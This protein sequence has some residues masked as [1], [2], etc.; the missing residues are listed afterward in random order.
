MLST[1]HGKCQRLANRTSSPQLSPVL[2]RVGSGGDGASAQLRPTSA[3]T[4][5]PCWL[6]FEVPSPSYCDTDICLGLEEKLL[7]KRNLCFVPMGIKPASQAMP[8]PVGGS[9]VQLM[10]SVAQ[11]CFVLFYFFQKSC[12]FI[13]PTFSLPI[14]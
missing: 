7:L 11:V 4:A 9:R 6:V 10:A 12:P 13:F 3:N 1:N 2:Q 8:F 5:L 14:R